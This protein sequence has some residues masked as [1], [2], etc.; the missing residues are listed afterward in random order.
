MSK[1]FNMRYSEK[2]MK[3]IENFKKDKGFTSK[4]QAI[5]FLI[6]YAL[7]NLKSDLIKK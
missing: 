5:T 2:L 1:T 4:T 3:E 7:D 6:R